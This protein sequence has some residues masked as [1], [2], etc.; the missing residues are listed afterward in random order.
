LFIRAGNGRVVTFVTNPENNDGRVIYTYVG[1]VANGT[2]HRVDVQGWERLWTEYVNAATGHGF[3]TVGEPIFSPDGKRIASS[4]YAMETCEINARLEIYRLT[5]SIPVRELEIEPRDCLTDI[6]WAP[7]ELR[8][9]AAD[10]L[11][12]LADSKRPAGAP[13]QGSPADTGGYVSRRMLA[14]RDGNTW[15][16]VSLP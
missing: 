16:I 9:L 12:F 5:D 11:A 3:D 2:L 7:H 4:I 15:R 14:V 13:P 10:T 6:G 8:W 1:R